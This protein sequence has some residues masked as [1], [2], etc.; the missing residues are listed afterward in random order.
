MRPAILLPLLLSAAAH[1]VADGSGAVWATPHDSYSSSVGVLGCKINTDRVAYWP[2]T[3]DCSNICISLSYEGRSVK[4]LRVDQS[5]GAYDVSYDAWNYLYT[6]HSAKDKPTVG[7]AV[8]MAFKNLDA[9]SCASLIHTD[10]NKLPLSAA[11]SMN[12]LASCLDQPDSWIAQNYVLYN[13]LDAI[14]SR[15][16]DEECA[17][18]WPAANQATCPHSIGQPVDLTT[19]PVY[20][21][22]Y[23]TGK[24]VLASSGQEV[25]N[26][27]G[28]PGRKMWQPSVNGLA[29]LVAISCLLMH[30]FPHHL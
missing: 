11:N 13:V 5:G 28:S 6:G 30:P 24:L 12:F 17:L 2:G 19:A 20:N 7:G 14:C 4:L 3:I 8:P 16:Y 18:D 9:S 26:V 15:G 22:Q 21:V 1:V 29:M 23:G 27:A 25:A 10:G